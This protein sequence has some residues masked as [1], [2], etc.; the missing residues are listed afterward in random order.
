MESKLYPSSCSLYLMIVVIVFSIGPHCVIADF[1]CI[2][3]Q[4]FSGAPTFENALRLKMDTVESALRQC[5]PSFSFTH[6]VSDAQIVDAIGHL[7]KCNRHAATNLSR[8]VQS[9]HTDLVSG[10]QSCCNTQ[11]LGKRRRRRSQIVDGDGEMILQ[12]SRARRRASLM[13]RLADLVASRSRRL[14]ED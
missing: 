3:T 5:F 6:G 4:C 14:L 12:D 9:Y 8:M 13:Q 1:Q 7:R 2:R 10:W 11:S